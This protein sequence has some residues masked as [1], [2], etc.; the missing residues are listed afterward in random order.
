MFADMRVGL[1]QGI[2][3]PGR[4]LPGVLIQI[5]LDGPID[6]PVGQQTRDDGPGLHPRA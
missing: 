4:G 6:I 2:N 3:E 1:F 5:V